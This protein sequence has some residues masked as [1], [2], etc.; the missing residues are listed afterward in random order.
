MTRGVRA[1][2]LR[3]EQPTPLPPG[4]RTELR[5]RVADAARLRENVLRE[6]KRQRRNAEMEIAASYERVRLAAVEAFERE[7][8]AI[9][10]EINARAGRS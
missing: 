3:G 8:K 10:D 5:A 2:Q 6:A 1:R 7:R 4:L 9:T